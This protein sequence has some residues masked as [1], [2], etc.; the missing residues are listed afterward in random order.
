MAA[1]QAAATQ[2]SSAT[3]REPGDSIAA[4]AALDKVSGCLRAWSRCG[5][6][7][8]RLGPWSSAFLGRIAEDLSLRY[9]CMS[10]KY[11]MSLL[12]IIPTVG[13]DR[14]TTD[15]E[16]MGDAVIHR[17]VAFIFPSVAGTTAP[18][19]IGPSSADLAVLGSARA[20][21]FGHRHNR[22][23]R[24]PTRTT[25]E[26]TAPRCLKIFGVKWNCNGRREA[27]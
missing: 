24:L 7:R 18:A 9:S 2:A 25:D 5:F 3:R 13:V 26:I 16:Q 22:F 21:S 19:P 12:D 4:T 17:G 11:R 1:A 14:R 27:R 10:S 15:A 8:A 20:S 23:W 6:S